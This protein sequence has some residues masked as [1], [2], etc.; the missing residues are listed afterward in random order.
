MIN[1]SE[2]VK[3][4][5]VNGYGW[6]VSPGVPWCAVGDWVRLGDRVTL[7]DRVRL[8]DGVTLG[9]GVRLGDG[10]N[11]PKG[12]HAVDLGVSDG[13]RKVL[14]MVDGDPWI[15]AGC[16][17]FTLADAIDHWSYH[18]KDR[19]ATKAQMVY[20]QALVDILKTP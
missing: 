12:Q 17:W 1:A 14:V 4:W 16:R 10:V 19:R 5:P 20:A 6:S 15:S 3:S 7:G 13:Y 8:G 18:K 11:V 9:D 2:I